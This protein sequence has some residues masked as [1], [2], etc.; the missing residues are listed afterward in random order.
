LDINSASYEEL[1][2]LPGIGPK[3]AERIVAH[4]PYQNVDDLDKVPGI[5]PVMLDRLRPLIRTE[6]TA[7]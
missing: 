3:L 7:P 6:N 2:K 1:V 4:R 5:G